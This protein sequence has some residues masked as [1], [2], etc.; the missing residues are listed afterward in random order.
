M[1][2]M[3]KIAFFHPAALSRM[4]ASDAQRPIPESAGNH[5]YEWGHAGDDQT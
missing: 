3:G 1:S 2:N 4:R 5:E